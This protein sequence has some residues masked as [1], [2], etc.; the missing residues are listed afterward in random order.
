[1]EGDAALCRASL[2]E[3]GR[4][5]RFQEITPS[6]KLRGQ[7]LWQVRLSPGRRPAPT[8]T[9]PSNNTTV[10]TTAFVN[11]ARLG[12][13]PSSL[14]CGTGA[15][16]GW[17]CGTGA[18][19]TDGGGQINVNTGTGP[20]LGGVIVTLTLSATHSA[21]FCSISPTSAAAAAAT[22]EVVTSS[23]GGN[24]L[25]LTN[26]NTALMASTSYGWAYTCSLVN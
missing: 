17:A 8:P 24:N 2:A 16:I 5:S 13:S 3:P 23:V 15:G 21:V 25:T 6:R 26:A 1:M 4:W 11:T 12:G 18:A 9:I 22:A 19:S 10:A 20:V 7:R 14:T